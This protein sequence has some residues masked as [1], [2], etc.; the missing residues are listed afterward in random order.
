[1]FMEVYVYMDAWMSQQWLLPTVSSCC[2]QVKLEKKGKI[3]TVDVDGL[4]LTTEIPELQAKELSLMDIFLG[5]GVL[6]ILILYRWQIVT[7]LFS[8]DQ[9]FP[10]ERSLSHKH[11]IMGQ[12]ERWGF[13]F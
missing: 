9:S 13:S 7:N 5:E 10:I 12:N 1:M 11:I 4:K 2:R 8:D 3:A 6:V